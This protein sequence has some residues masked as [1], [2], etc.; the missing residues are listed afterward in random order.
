MSI[1]QFFVLLLQEWKRN[2]LKDK[3]VWNFFFFFDLG[4][5]FLIS[6]LEPQGT[7]GHQNHRT[8]CIGNDL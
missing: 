5:I 6:F 8:V 7:C 1:C 4:I 2:N 3:M